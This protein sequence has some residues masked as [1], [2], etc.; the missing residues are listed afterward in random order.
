MARP[1]RYAIWLVMIF[2]LIIIPTT[3]VAQEETETASPPTATF[4]ATATASPTVTSTVT[5]TATSTTTETATHTATVTN[6]ATATDIATSTDAPTETLAPSPELT[7]ELIESA[8]EPAIE[9]TEELA[10][11]VTEPVIELTEELVQ[12]VT[13]EFVE[14]VVTATQTEEVPIFPPSII[15]PI[16][17]GAFEVSSSANNVVMFGTSSVP[18]A[19][20]ALFVRGGD[21]WR[22][23][24]DN[25]TSA[26]PETQITDLGGIT[27]ASWSPDRSEIAFVRDDPTTSNTSAGVPYVMPTPTSTAVTAEVITYRYVHYGIAWSNDGT[28][29]AISSEGDIKVIEYSKCTGTSGPICGGT[30]SAL[31]LSQPNVVVIADAGS[32]GLP[33]FRYPAWSPDDAYIYHSYDGYND[34]NPNKSLERRELLYVEGELYAYSLSALL[35]PDTNFDVFHPSVSPDGN[36]VAF[37]AGGSL[38]IYDVTTQTS[39]SVNTGGI[40]SIW[41]P[42]W[43]S[44]GTELGFYT[45]SN[46]NVYV[47]SNITED[48]NEYTATV[49]QK[50]S[51]GNGYS[52]FVWGH[53]IAPQGPPPDPTATATNTATP[54]ATPTEAPDDSPPGIL[55]SLPAIVFSN[56]YGGDSE[57]YKAT[58]I[59]STQLTDNADEDTNPAYAPDGQKI[60]FQSDRDGTLEIYRMDIDGT[61]EYSLTI[62][63]GIEPDW[64]PDSSVVV[65]ARGSNLHRINDDRLN[66]SQLTNHPSGEAH[67]PAISSNG[68]WIVYV[69]DGILYVIDG[70][71]TTACISYE[72][73]SGTSHAYPAWSPDGTQLVWSS[74]DDLYIATVDTTGATPQ[75]VGITELTDANSPQKDTHPT[76]ATDGQSILFESNR[77]GEISLFEFDLTVSAPATASS[78]IIV[79]Q[80]LDP[81][82]TPNPNELASD[83]QDPNTNLVTQPSTEI[84]CVSRLVLGVNIRADHY[85]TASI[86]YFVGSDSDPWRLKLTG[87]AD[88]PEIGRYYLVEAAYESGLLSAENASYSGWLSAQITSGNLCDASQTAANISDQKLPVLNVFV[89][90]PAPIGTATAIPVPSPTPTSP[91]DHSD[92][93]SMPMVNANPI[94]L[95][96][97]GLHRDANPSIGIMRGDLVLGLDMNPKDIAGQSHNLI[98]PNFSVVGPDPNVAEIVAIDTMI[99]NG[100]E[101]G[102]FV[103]V[104]IETQ[105]LPIEI[106]NRLAG[107]TVSS[108]QYNN[109]PADGRYQS[110]SNVTTGAIYI[111]YGHL[112]TV[113]TTLQVGQ[114]VPPNTFIGISGETGLDDDGFASID[115]GAKHLHIATF[116]APESPLPPIPDRIARDDYQ[117]F[118]N[119]YDLGANGNPDHLANYGMNFLVNPLVLWPSTQDRTSCPYWRI[120]Q[121][122]GATN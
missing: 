36:L 98:V 72:L 117:W 89:N 90:P 57:I 47:L 23:D 81:T 109:S 1:G 30:T 2:I 68:N 22:L 76:W 21:I 3:L 48:T 10:P 41:S 4:T 12:E 25:C 67:S 108:T 84:Y 17:P 107:T 45:T 43:S 42:S 61:N 83:I 85:P 74:S 18:Y 52:Q 110:I 115:P 93:F 16:M 6:T 5:A 8:T 102:N 64:Y 39:K 114:R 122:E 79:Q 44:S 49:S 26:C 7:A 116:Y 106:L 97:C 99:E 92:V 24:L 94:Q 121:N 71:C 59:S 14:S 95:S 65:F 82:P 13:A 87:Y 32:S 78:S 113:S 56:S 54:T 86:A 55:V 60:A 58:G 11:E 112:D 66:A 40:S 96:R 105:Y 88:I 50:T 34:G 51:T 119:A 33:P 101:I 31:S 29:I 91:P 28:M 100:Q 35:I 20:S 46:N 75:L 120:L 15:V 62:A 9:V 70:N 38:R 53:P 69:H 104:R 37:V 80:Q 19:N 118:F 27:D 111:G 63:G 73:L 103:G 77:N